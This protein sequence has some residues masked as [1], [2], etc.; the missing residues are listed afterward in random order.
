M[1]LYLGIDVGATW[2]RAILIDENL[3]VFKRLKI[4]TGVNPLADVAV[5]VEKWS[6]DSIGVGSIGPMDLRS[7]RVVNSPNSPS[8]QFP[9]VE[10]LKKFGKPV[11]V[12]NDCVA[13]VWGEYVFKH[14]VENLVYVTLSTGV[15]IGAIVNGT[16]LLGKDGNAHELGHAV[17]DFRSGR[18]CGCGGFGHFEAY[19]GGANI[20]KWFQELTGE[21]LN[22]AAEVFKR[23]RDGD[24]KARQFIDLWL[25]ALAAGI[26][27]VIAAYDP[28]LLIIGGSIGLNNWDIISRDLPIR[29]KKYL[30]VRPPAIT[31]ASFGDDEV[32]IGAAALAYRVPDS[33]KKF[34]YPR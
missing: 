18:Q 5:A 28:E 23:Y 15:G 14:R 6:F 33:L 12:A 22:D 26:A 34:G 10:P 25:D 4:R 11:V 9:L 1:A 21:A 3:Q 29:L 2:T 7:G 13:A 31:Q 32:A 17:I 19:V 8:R 30:G 16:L 24:F 20:P 27:T